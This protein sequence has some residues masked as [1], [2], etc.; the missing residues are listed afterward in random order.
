[1]VRLRRTSDIAAKA[2]IVTISL[3]AGDAAA[4]AAFGA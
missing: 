3:K 4:V 1:M 2:T